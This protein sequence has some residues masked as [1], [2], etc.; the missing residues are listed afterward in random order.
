VAR[1][2]LAGDRMETM[3]GT[4]RSPS[5]VPFT[6]RDPFRIMREMIRWE[7]FREMSA[8]VPRMLGR[9][10]WRPAFEVRE[11]ESSLRI[12]ADVPGVSRDEVAIYL[13]GNRLVIS[14]KRE[15]EERG[16]DERV[17]AHER[18]FGAFT[19]KFK[20]PDYVETEHVSSELRD[21]VLTVVI[22][23]KAGEKSRKIAIGGPAAKA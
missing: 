7:P 16:K 11:N 13:T 1:D 2:S 18:A 15:L 10:A 14:G 4:G 19:R 12:L 17:R 5:D 23:K 3:T 20:L 8:W 22:P 9:G 21:G 6:Q